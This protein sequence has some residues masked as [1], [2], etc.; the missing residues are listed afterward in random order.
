MCRSSRLRRFPSLPPVFAFDVVPAALA[1]GLNRL[2]VT[3]RVTSMRNYATVQPFLW[4]GEPV[5]RP[6]LPACYT[7][8]VQPATS[9]SAPGPSATWSSAGRCRASHC[10][11][12]ADCSSIA[13]TSTNS[14]KQAA[15][16]PDTIAA[17]RGSPP[18][19][20]R[21]TRGSPFAR[22]RGPHTPKISRRVG[23]RKLYGYDTRNPKCIGPNLE[24]ETYDRAIEKR[25]AW[26]VR[27]GWSA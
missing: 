11:A 23:R 12:C 13:A 26:Y 19:A 7:S 8:R 5:G 9:V 15:S 18:P 24:G 1:S 2:R 6:M 20:G 27:P 3:F 17:S 21:A 16:P 10:P 25:G 22:S 4:S 14:S